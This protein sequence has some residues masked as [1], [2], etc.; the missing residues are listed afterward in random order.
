MVKKWQTQKWVLT[1]SFR[2]LIFKAFYNCYQRRAKIA[3]PGNSLGL[4]HSHN[5]VPDKGNAKEIVDILNGQV[6][7]NCS[8]GLVAGFPIIPL[9]S[10]IINAA[11][12]MHSSSQSLESR[13]ILNLVK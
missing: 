7:E 6:E 4:D 2:Y 8:K 11:L 9:L 13:Q 12:Q 3:W 5:L 10:I 1:F